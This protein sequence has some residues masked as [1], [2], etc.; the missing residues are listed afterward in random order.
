MTLMQGWVIKQSRSRSRI[1]MKF[2]SLTINF[3]LHMD[4]D[5]TDHH[6][7]EKNL[8]KRQPVCRFWLSYQVQDHFLPQSIVWVT[9]KRSGCKSVLWKRGKKICELEDWARQREWNYFLMESVTT[10]LID[11]YDQCIKHLLFWKLIGF[12]MPFLCPTT[13]LNLFCVF[14]HDYHQK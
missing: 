12:S 4:L 14:W 9:S 2:M 6:K 5:L 7:S 1:G 13:C 10:M 8:T 11:R 3:L